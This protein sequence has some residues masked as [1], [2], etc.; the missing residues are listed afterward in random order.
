MHLM[1]SAVSLLCP[2]F[3]VIGT[4]KSCA[5]ASSILAFLTNPSTPC[6]LIIGNPCTTHPVYSYLT[7]FIYSAHPIEI[8]FA[9]QYSLIYA[10]ILLWLGRICDQAGIQFRVL[11][12]SKG[13]GLE[14]YIPYFYCSPHIRACLT[15]P[16][17]LSG[18]IEP[19]LIANCIVLAC[20]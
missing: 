8:L 2:C 13:P 10:F 16:Y 20:K 19:K 15:S 3:P 11:N 6:S 9:S 17:Q 7:D 5:L 18:A 4:S 12:R 14:C 1:D